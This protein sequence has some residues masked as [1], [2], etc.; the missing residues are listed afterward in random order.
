MMLVDPSC[1][2][3]ATEALKSINKYHE[4]FTRAQLKGPVPEPDFDVI[5]LSEHFRRMDEAIAREAAR[6]TKR[7]ETEIVHTL[8][9]SP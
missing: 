5:S 8:A 6:K 2:P 7:L 9:A 3:T 1:R 4:G